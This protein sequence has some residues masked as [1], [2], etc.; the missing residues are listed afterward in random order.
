M[1]L[2]NEKHTCTHSYGHT[3]HLHIHARTHPAIQILHINAAC[4]P[5]SSS[6]RLSFLLFSQLHLF[7]SPLQVGDKLVMGNSLLGDGWMDGSCDACEQN[8]AA[9]LVS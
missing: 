3:G 4:N 2:L 9:S 8:A 5:L 1:V 7:S 6:Y